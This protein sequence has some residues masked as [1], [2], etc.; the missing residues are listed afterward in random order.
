[1][2]LEV[3]P[4]DA[5]LLGRHLGAGFAGLGEPDG[6]CL[7]AAFHRL[8]GTTALE[9]AVLPLAHDSGYI[10]GGTF[11]FRCHEESSGR[12]SGR[13]KFL[14]AREQLLTQSL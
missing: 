3:L 13:L 8:A 2:P 5:F 4:A 12:L 9:R 11:L 14:L 7:L 6:D 1:M 10:S